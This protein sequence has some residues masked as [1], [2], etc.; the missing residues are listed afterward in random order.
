MPTLETKSTYMTNNY[1]YYYFH[2]LAE[3]V[4]VVPVKKL[5]LKIK[6]NIIFLLVV[7]VLWIAVALPSIRGRAASA[8]C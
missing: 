5:F 6:L 8:F 2:Y 4:P 1:Y 7:L 3:S